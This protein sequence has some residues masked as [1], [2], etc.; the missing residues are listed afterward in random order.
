MPNL[1]TEIL[2]KRRTTLLAEIA[3]LQGRVAE[4]DYLLGL[5]GVVGSPLSPTVIEVSPAPVTEFV[6]GIIVKARNPR[7]LK[8]A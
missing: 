7:K 8:K 6:T 2:T 5:S 1:P 3:T 4:L